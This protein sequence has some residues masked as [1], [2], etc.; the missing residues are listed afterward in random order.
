[1]SLRRQR[2]SRSGQE[3]VEA[4]RIE[5]HHDVVSDHKSRRGAAVVRAD[6]L[7]DKF[8]L[9]G[10]VALF[11]FDTSILEVGLGCP[12]RRSARLRKNDDLLRHGRNG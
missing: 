4:L 5:A 6:K 1:M 9:G 11:E 7:K 12:A 2:P 8:F 3:F 10:D